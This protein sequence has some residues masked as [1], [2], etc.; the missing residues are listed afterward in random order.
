MDLATLVSTYLG[1]SDSDYL[2]SLFLYADSSESYY[3]E[4]YER[5]VDAENTV[6]DIEEIISYYAL[7][8]DDFIYALNLE[9]VSF[10]DFNDTL[11]F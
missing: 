5:I 8:L 10:D 7:T 1:E 11:A 9:Y 4:I 3:F 2:A 6:D